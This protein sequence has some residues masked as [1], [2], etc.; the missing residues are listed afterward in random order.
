MDYQEVYNALK[1]ANTGLETMNIKGKKYVMVKD[2]VKAFREHFPDWKLTTNMVYHDDHQ[3]IFKASILDEDGHV[4]ATGHAK[5][6]EGST[7]INRTSHVENCETSAI[8]RALAAFG[9]GIDDS[10][11]SA[12]EVANAVMQQGYITE[13]EFRDLETLC[14]QHN[15]DLSW[16]LATA[17]ATSGRAITKEGYVK[18]VKAAEALNG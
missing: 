7:N 2:R 11:G 8:G 16:M 5:E 4:I 13:R 12:D 14:K 15:K 3:V 6:D 17:G 9:I 18:V 10:F 1:A